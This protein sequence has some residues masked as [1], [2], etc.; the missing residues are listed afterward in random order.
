MALMNPQPP[1]RKTV[2][3][4]GS[5]EFNDYSEV[6]A[7]LKM[8]KKPLHIVSGGAPGADSIAEVWAKKNNVPCTVELADWE[9]Y[10]RAAG[11]IRNQKMLDAHK[12]VLVLAFPVGDS[13]GT[14]DMVRRA[15]KAGVGVLIYGELGTSAPDEQEQLLLHALKMAQKALSIPHPDN[16]VNDVQHDALQAVENALLP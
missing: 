8:L 2:L 10:G 11:P 15:R 12:P 4:C 14:R 6:D 7:I 16:A 13:P 5:R 3:V 1:H 9:T